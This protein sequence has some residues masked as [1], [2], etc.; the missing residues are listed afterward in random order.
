[1]KIRLLSIF[2]LIIVLLSC[3][4]NDSNVQGKVDEFIKEIQK[5]DKNY[6]SEQEFF[7]E[8]N[9][10]ELKKD[11][12]YS[13]LKANNKV[14]KDLAIKIDDFITGFAEVSI[15]KH[16]FKGNIEARKDLLK[17]V[18]FLKK[19]IDNGWGK[20]ESYGLT[21]NQE[22]KNWMKINMEYKAFIESVDKLKSQFGIIRLNLTFR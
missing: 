1:M 22:K 16:E 6:L 21:L 4:S 8:V 12:I 17:R 19:D 3:G 7:T 18:Q 11:R 20:K 2:V 5:A 14:N 13:Q 9:S 10:L 15:K